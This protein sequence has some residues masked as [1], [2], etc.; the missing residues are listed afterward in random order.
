MSGVVLTL[1]I[2]M[3]LTYV[4]NKYW[5]RLTNYWV[6]LKSQACALSLW[7]S[8]IST[9]YLLTDQKTVWIIH[10]TTSK[11]VHTSLLSIK[12]NKC[13]LIQWRLLIRAGFLLL[14]FAFIFL[15]LGL[16]LLHT[17][18][19][20]S[21]NTLPSFLCKYKFY[22]VDDNEDQVK[23]NWKNLPKEAWMFKQSW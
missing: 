16:N 6:V 12:T 11:V 1:I 2:S 14:V 20:K 15:W 17:L 10:L 7:L 19:D 9:V 13:D 21:K 5:L 4:K 18:N 3:I 8:I 22:F 23:I